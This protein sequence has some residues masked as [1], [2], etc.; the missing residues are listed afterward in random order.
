MFA[1]AAASSAGSATSGST[2]GTYLDWDVFFIA[3]SEII[4][5]TA[6]TLYVS[7]TLNQTLQFS[8]AVA[9]SEVSAHPS[10][11]QRLADTDGARV[12]PIPDEF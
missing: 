12:R 6:S 7:G 1:I 5:D 8:G 9:E 10:G 11:G 4:L 2:E 3:S